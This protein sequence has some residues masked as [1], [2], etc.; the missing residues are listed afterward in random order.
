M[1]SNANKA[2]TANELADKV[3][4]DPK[5]VRAYLRA[6][7]PRTSEEKNTRWEIDAKTQK[8]VTEHYEALNKAAE[9]S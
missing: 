4:R 2:I 3:G 9:A 5:S 1:A 8:A 7:F 6:N